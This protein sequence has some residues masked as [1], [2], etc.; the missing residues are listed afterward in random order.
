MKVYGKRGKRSHII[1]PIQS[2][3]EDVEFSEDDDDGH[4]Q[5]IDLKTSST[6][7]IISRDTTR[8]TSKEFSTTLQTTVESV[9]Q[10]VIAYRSDSLELETKDE[11]NDDFKKEESKLDAFDFMSNTAPKKKK[12]KT[13]YRKERLIEEDDEDIDTSQ[14][15]VVNDVNRYISSLKDAVDPNN[16]A[17]NTDIL[18]KLFEEPLQESIKGTDLDKKN[19]QRLYGRNRTFLINNDDE[20]NLELEVSDADIDQ[21]IPLTTMQRLEA[22]H[23]YNDLKNMGTDLK[24][25]NDLD[26]LTRKR[27]SSI[28]LASELLHLC[29]NLENDDQFRMFILEH[30]S[31][32]IWRWSLTCFRTILEE[33]YNHEFLS[34]LLLLQGYILSTLPLDTDSLPEEIDMFISALYDQIYFKVLVIRQVEV[35]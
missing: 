18:K 13:N 2:K 14:L 32:D 19:H 20:E 33:N 16:D 22:T 11:S 34:V 17:K 29:L 28:D 30:H 35:I 23:H 9:R 6:N 8:P 31:E 5:S 3:F 21:K 15:K 25:E 27:L 24:Y 12:R 10:H 4:Q 26:F 1:I 7:S